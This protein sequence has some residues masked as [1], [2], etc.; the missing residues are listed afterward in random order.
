MEKASPFVPAEIH[1]HT[2]ADEGGNL[3]ILSIRT[4]EGIL[5]IA[6]DC[7]AADAIVSA[8]GSIRPKLDASEK[9]SPAGNRARR[10]SGGRSDQRIRLS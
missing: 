9:E 5:D 1:I 10:P 7:H 3:G 8:I 4:T 6:L 2:V